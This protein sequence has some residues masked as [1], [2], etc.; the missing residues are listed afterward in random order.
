MADESSGGLARAG[1]CVNARLEKKI[2]RSML[3]LVV[4]YSVV[5][6]PVQ[7]QSFQGSNLLPYFFFLWSKGGSYPHP[8]GSRYS[9]GICRQSICLSS[10]VTREVCKSIK[11]ML[12]G[13]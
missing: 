2:D 11:S 8:N 7:N 4:R 12:V 3:I 5:Y 10:D 13:I 1:D 9:E 6:S